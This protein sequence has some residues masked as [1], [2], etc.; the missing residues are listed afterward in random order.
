MHALSLPLCRCCA[1]EMP[2]VSAVWDIRRGFIASGIG[3]HVAQAAAQP[4]GLDMQG[5]VLFLRLPDHCTP[6]DVAEA[7][8]EATKQLVPRLQCE[9]ARDVQVNRAGTSCVQD[10]VWHTA[11]VV[12]TAAPHWFTAA[13]PT[14]AHEV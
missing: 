1:G 8:Q 11:C 4:G 2:Q 12:C 7:M 10:R 13:A 9:P 14:A 5:Q 6:A 3:A